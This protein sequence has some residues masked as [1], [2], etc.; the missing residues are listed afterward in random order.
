[1]EEYEY[2]VLGGL[3]PYAYDGPLGGKALSPERQG[4]TDPGTRQWQAGGI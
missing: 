2:W 4:P 3:R 1:M